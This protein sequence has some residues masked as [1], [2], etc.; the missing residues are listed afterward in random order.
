MSWLEALVLGIVQG[1]TEFLPVSSSGH[2]QIGNA[3]FGVSGENLAFTVV[4]HA[5]TVCSTIIVL[6]REIAALLK[7]L[8]RFSWNPETI[9]I[10]KIVVSM[11]PV[12][13]IGFFFKDYVE[14]IFGSG[15]LIVGICLLILRQAQNLCFK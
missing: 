7:G 4:V 13:I 8:F 11:I 2:L 15:L 14:G 12:A 9:Y 3:L 6:R 5:A 10:A 1:L